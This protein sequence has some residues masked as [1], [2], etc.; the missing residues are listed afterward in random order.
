MKLKLVWKVCAVVV[1]VM[2][3]VI[4]IAPSV[5]LD[6]FVVRSLSSAFLLLA[7]LAALLLSRRW[8]Q[9]PLTSA[10]C[11]IFDA[12]APRPAPSP[13]QLCVIRC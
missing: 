13:T 12:V 11:V 4:L 2:L 10:L 3:A 6:D 9:N 7:F 8:I 5:D 1:A